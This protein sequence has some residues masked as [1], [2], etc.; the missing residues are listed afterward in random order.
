MERFGVRIQRSVLRGF[1][2]GDKRNRLFCHPDLNAQLSV[3]RNALDFGKVPLLVTQ[4]THGTCLEPSL[5]AIQVKDVPAISKGNGKTIVICR[6]RIGLVF[7]RGFVQGV[8]A[9]GALYEG[10]CV[11]Q[12]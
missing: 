8:S 6:R 3:A 1:F 11:K 9:N 2:A 4:G 5:N 12:L 7:N 10:E